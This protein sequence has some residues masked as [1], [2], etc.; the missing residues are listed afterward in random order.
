MNDP[1]KCLTCGLAWTSEE[2]R[3]LPFFR[4]VVDHN[5]CDNVVI[6]HCPKCNPKFVEVLEWLES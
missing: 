2:V 1:L 4:L 3:A 6:K 5:C